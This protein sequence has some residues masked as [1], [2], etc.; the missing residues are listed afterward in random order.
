MKQHA[1]YVTAEA[2]RLA[3]EISEA[4]AQQTNAPARNLLR[5]SHGLAVATGIF[6]EHV[7]KLLFPSRP[8]SPEIT[9]KTL[10]AVR[11]GFIK[12]YEQTNAELA[13]LLDSTTKS[14]ETGKQNVLKE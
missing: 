10:M 4:T 8:L 1:D 5:E 9:E 12:A 13:R 7:G 11:Q 3:A 2:R 14:T 6:Q